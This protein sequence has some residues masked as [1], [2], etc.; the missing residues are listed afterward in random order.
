[1]AYQDPF[2]SI[3]YGCYIIYDIV[4]IIYDITYVIYDITY[5]V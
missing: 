4:Y 3:S 1:M 2:F 5:E